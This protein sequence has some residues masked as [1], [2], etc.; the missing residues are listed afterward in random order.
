LQQAIFV[1]EVTS[2]FHQN[3]FVSE[4]VRSARWVRQFTYADCKLHTDFG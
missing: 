1:V 3:Y 2:S 4:M